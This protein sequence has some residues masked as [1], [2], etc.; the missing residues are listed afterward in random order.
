MKQ[1]GFMLQHP[2]H[3]TAST[4]EGLDAILAASALCEQVRVFFV[5]DGVYAL[6]KE[7]YPRG[8]GARD[9]AKTFGLLTLYEIN[10]VIV[11][12]QSLSQRGISPDQ[13]I[14]SVTIL[15]AIALSKKL[16]ACDIL[17]SF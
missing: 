2:P 10:D 11:C 16:A 6:K 13:L 3:G 17:L 9:I 4:R 7:Q 1:L 5:H 8:V 15:P 14:L 12:E